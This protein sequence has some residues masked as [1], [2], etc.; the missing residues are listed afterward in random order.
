[1]KRDTLFFVREDTTTAEIGN[2]RRFFF[3]L[4]TSRGKRN[5]EKLL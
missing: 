5:N 3:R 1:M 4:P 2:N